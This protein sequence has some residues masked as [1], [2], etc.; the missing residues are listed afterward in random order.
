MDLIATHSIILLSL[1]AV[2]GYSPNTDNPIN[3]PTFSTYSNHI[4]ELEISIGEYPPQPHPP[5]TQPALL[6][7]Q[8]RIAVVLVT[9]TILAP[10][11]W[12]AWGYLGR[13]VQ[14]KAQ[15]RSTHLGGHSEAVSGP[16]GKVSP[17]I[18]MDDSALYVLKT[19]ASHRR[20]VTVV[21][22]GT[23]HFIPILHPQTPTTP[24]S[25]PCQSVGRHIQRIWNWLPIKP[26]DQA[27]S[28]S[29]QDRHSLRRS[30][31]TG[32]RELG[33]GLLEPKQY[34][35]LLVGVDTMDQKDAENDTEYLRQM[36][37]SLPDRSLI[38]YECIYGPNTTLDAI[39]ETALALLDDARTASSP[40]RTFMLFTGT[41][42]DNNTMCLTDGQVLSAS[43]LS[44]WLSI[45]PIDQANQSISL[46]FD[47]CRM[48]ASRLAIAFQSVE[49][50][51]SCCVGEFAYAIR[52]SV[53]K[54]IPRS[55]FLLAIFLAAYDM[56]VHRLDGCYFEA[57]FAFHIKELSDLILHKYGRQHQ[58]RC[59]HCPPRK[60]CDPPVAQNPDLQQAGRAL[61]N[62]G[63]LI[64]EYFPQHACE[65][66]LAVENEM[67][68]AE[69]PG[70]LCPLS[71]SRA[72][73]SNK[74]TLKDET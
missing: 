21:F 36:F 26:S 12:L 44:Q 40:S 32:A 2:L 1:V 73:K 46:L 38:R 47:I 49:L 23:P 13:S 19:Q 64:A 66:F 63:M 42:D 43:D 37:E 34:F 3:N 65:V 60:Q 41:G 50:A 6:Q 56:N 71:A 57:A 17:E 59:F 29:P 58:N 74:P 68:Q 4:N 24:Y 18:P 52:L 7:A 5:N 70:R 39:R 48:A 62:L 31:Y 51:W 9:T 28:I 15:V 35:F 53:N 54:L 25:D 14:S 72:K 33:K 11:M 69:F 20:P 8:W 16:M 27:V 45:S 22:A 61:V 30:L 10:V 67:L 55:I